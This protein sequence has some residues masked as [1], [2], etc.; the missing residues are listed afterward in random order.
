MTE[1]KNKEIKGNK[2]NDRIEDYRNK[3]NE[4]NKRIE[5]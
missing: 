2:N 5:E 1:Q 3:G 4:N